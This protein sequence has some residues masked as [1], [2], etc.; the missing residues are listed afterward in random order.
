MRIGYACLCLLLVAK[1]LHANI[2]IYKWED[3]NG[4]VHF[5]DKPHPGAETI[6]VRPTKTYSP[7]QTGTSPKPAQPENTQPL[8]IE[9]KQKP[10][11]YTQVKIV[12]PKNQATIRSNTGE[13][14]VI[15]HTEPKLD[16][17]QGDRLLLLYD[18]KP[19]GKPQ[20]EPAFSLT[21]VYRGTHNLQVQVI[22]QSG[23]VVVSS[24]PVTVFIHHTL[25]PL[26]R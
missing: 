16:L 20:S 12:D 5:S 23:R 7:S 1:Q 17:E 18:G 25:R 21:H 11:T 15:A 26:P 10:T 22:D 4:N 14:T 6:T 2:E 8:K 13:L 24:N 3:E 19:Y 9:P